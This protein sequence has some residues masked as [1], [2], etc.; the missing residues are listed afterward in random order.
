[1]PPGSPTSARSCR[2]GDDP[3]AI[4][5]CCRTA[6]E[7][8]AR[9]VKT[10]FPQPASAIADAVGCGIPVVL[11]GGDPRDPSRSLADA[12][13][14]MAAG[15]AGV[16]FGRNVWGATDPA[17]M[18]RD[19]G[20]I[21]HGAAAPVVTAPLRLGVVGPGDVAERDYL[22]EL[23][24][25][26]GRAEIVAF[27]SR[28]GERARRSRSAAPGRAATRGLRGA[29]AATPLSTPSSTSRRSACTPR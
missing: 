13:D 7:L 2:A 19:L 20:R 15:A 14:A 17:A 8:G 22:P 25:L 18:V 10:S 16:A 3:L 12:A 24:R 29:A 23:G 9:V 11:A 5:A 21:V 1:M 26:A 6:A 27:A 28:D 4:A